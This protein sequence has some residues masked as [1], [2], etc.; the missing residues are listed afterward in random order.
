MK[1]F[2][3]T[4][5]LAM[6]FPAAILGQDVSSNLQIIE[7]ATVTVLDSVC[8]A[9]LNKDSALISVD[10]DGLVPEIRFFIRNG[11]LNNFPAKG[12]NVLRKNGRYRL[13]LT[14]FEA[15][16]VY[17]EVPSSL[18]GLDDS[19]KREIVVKLKGRVEHSGQGRVLSGFD[20]NR[21]I[22]DKIER[23]ILPQIE[24]SPYAFTRGRKETFS[25]WSRF[26]GPGIA[27]VSVV[28]MIFLFYSV[29]F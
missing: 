1:F 16:V 29:R 3:K 14:R 26:S 20:L 25:L 22:Q 28:S 23:E 12:W 17:R 21:V 13:V 19:I 4:S 24:K 11:L 2:V 6:L 15:G 27:I 9:H 5:L 8:S 18:L 7:T 10:V